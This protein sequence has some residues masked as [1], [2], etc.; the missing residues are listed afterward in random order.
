M[1]LI[2]PL[3][4]VNPE[5]VFSI[6]SQNPVGRAF[7][8]VCEAFFE[9]FP[10]RIPVFQLE[11]LLPTFGEHFF[12]QKGSKNLVRQAPLRQGAPR[13]GPFGVHFGVHFE[14]TLR[15]AGE[16]APVL[17]VPTDL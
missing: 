11:G 7:T 17:A 2:H 14:S 8:D 6:E 9:P 4:Q 5:T 15:S 10:L 1:R 13:G 16:L 12:V 3:E